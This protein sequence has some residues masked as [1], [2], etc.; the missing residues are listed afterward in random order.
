VVMRQ[1][2]VGGEHRQSPANIETSA[3]ALSSAE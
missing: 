1:N 3:L 2:T